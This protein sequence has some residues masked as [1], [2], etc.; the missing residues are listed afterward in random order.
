MNEPASTAML[1]AAAE[2]VLGADAVASTP[3]S[4]GGE[5]FAWYL[6]SVAGSL[7]RLGTRAPGSQPRTST[8]TRPRSTST[9]GPSASGCGCWPRP[10]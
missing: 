7:A 2:Q 10:R 9:S 4:L 8:S 6:E 1:A 5:D 3:Q